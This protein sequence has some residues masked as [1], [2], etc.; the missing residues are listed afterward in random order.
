MCPNETGKEQEEG[1]EKQPAWQ[2]RE[3]PP[4]GPGPGDGGAREALLYDAFAIVQS[5]V[6]FIT[7]FPLES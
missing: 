2:A 7:F 6:P 5:S 4:F 3:R 1:A